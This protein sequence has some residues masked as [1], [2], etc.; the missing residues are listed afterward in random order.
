MSGSHSQV[1]VGVSCPSCAKAVRAGI[2]FPPILP[3]D[4]Y[5]VCFIALIYSIC[6]EFL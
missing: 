6:P 4:L 1:R 2:F 3:H 5:C